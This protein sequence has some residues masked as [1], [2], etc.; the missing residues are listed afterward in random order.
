MSYEQYK[1]NMKEKGIDCYKR[2]IPKHKKPPQHCYKCGA[3]KH[4]NHKCEES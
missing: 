4:D 1:K 3:L 2:V